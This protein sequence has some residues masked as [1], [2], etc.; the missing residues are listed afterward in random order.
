MPTR[1]AKRAKGKKKPSKDLL[2]IRMAGVPELG[3]SLKS[4]GTRLKESD[5]APVDL[6]R[7]FLH[8]SAFAHNDNPSLTLTTPLEM[9]A[10][11]LPL[12]TLT[13]GT[14]PASYQS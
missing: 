2:I 4:R 10:P 8:Y 11:D 9:P 3:K 6:L 12:S 7:S 5:L 13:F 1:Q 14:S